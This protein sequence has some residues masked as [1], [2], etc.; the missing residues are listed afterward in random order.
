MENNF[1]YISE[2][3]NLNYPQTIEC[4]AKRRVKSMARN[5][6]FSFVVLAL[7]L[8]VLQFLNYLGE[9]YQIISI[10]SNA[11]TTL[12]TTV[13]YSMVAIGFC[14]LLGYSGLASLGTA[15]FI[16]V[17]AYTAFFCFE[18]WGM[19]Y[20]VCLLMTL[21]ISI[22]LGIA[23]GFV[24]LRIEGIYLAIITLGLSEILRNALQAIKASLSIG[25]YNVHLFG[26]SI[27]KS[28]VFYLIVVVFTVLIW[29]T[30]NLINS[31]TG[32]AM[33]AMKN[34]TPA[35]QAYG[36]S[37]MKYRL[38]AF[39]LST[40]YAAI[41]GVMYM[42]YFRSLTPSESALLKLATSLNILG[43]VIIGG[44]KSIWG[45]IVGVFIIYG[46]DKLF[47]QNIKFFNNNPDFITLFVGVLIIVVVMFFP[48]GLSQ[49]AKTAVYKLKMSR[50]KRRLRK[51]GTEE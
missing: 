46:I 44:A 17:G 12:G 1:N 15:G 11:L 35:A 10:S 39:V 4:A 27:P 51:Y 16:G 45:T 43:A 32:R 18:Q 49:L 22:I 29:I 34:S 7:I 50:Y 6:M 3:K 24:S 30:T 8:V 36:I 23:V 14:L 31:P 13:I 25:F 2:Y 38:L 28:V 41:G 26:Q 37:L 9:Y 47:L 20:I 40:C 21:A 33:L 48:G 5:P 19:P 42:M